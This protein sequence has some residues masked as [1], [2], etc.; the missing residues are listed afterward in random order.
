MSSPPSR[1]R[2]S[3]AIPHEHDAGDE[4]ED[5]VEDAHRNWWVSVIE[6]L[7]LRFHI[8]E[9]GQDLGAIRRGAGELDYNVLVLHLKST[10]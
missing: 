8:T 9:L 1:A 10:E 4:K 5:G 3:S 6:E 2:S 7:A